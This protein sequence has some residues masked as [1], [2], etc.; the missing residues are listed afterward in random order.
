MV[1]TMK[2]TVLFLVVIVLMIGACGC[3]MRDQNK[4]KDMVSYINNKYPDD[5]FEFVSLSG[6][7]IG[8]PTKTILVRSGKYPN[9]LVRVICDQVD[10][11]AV[12]T[13]TYLN[14]KFEKQTRNYIENALVDAFDTRVAVHYIPDDLT[15]FAEGTGETTFFEYISDETVY[16][17]FYAVVV[18]D[19]IDEEVVVSTVDE[20]FR[21][22]VLLGDI[23]FVDRAYT[24][25]VTGTEPFSVID[26]KQYTKKLFIQ[27]DGVDHY[28]TIEWTDLS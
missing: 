14:V 7:H 22:G 12:F 13:D 19:E 16:I 10:G 26:E 15:G 6:G 4:A 27:K 23:Y 20:A 1:I 21:E 8:S 5:T 18:L 3:N 9:S 11:E 25:I 24:D 17:Y 28:K 2:K